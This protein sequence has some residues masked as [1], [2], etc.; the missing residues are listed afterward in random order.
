MLLEDRLVLEQ[1]GVD[2]LEGGVGNGATLGGEVVG[3]YTRYIGKGV[4]AH[5]IVCSRHTRGSARGSTGVMGGGGYAGE[6]LAVYRG[7]WCRRTGG[8]VPVGGPRP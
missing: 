5:I 2:I 8:I 3:R 6:A 4:T 7:G 1:Q